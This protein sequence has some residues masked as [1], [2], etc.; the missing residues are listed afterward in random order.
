MKRNYPETIFTH[1]SSVTGERIMFDIE[2]PLVFL[3]ERQ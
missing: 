3:W 2:T 1:V